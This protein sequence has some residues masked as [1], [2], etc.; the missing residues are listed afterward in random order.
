MFG[1]GESEAIGT[2]ID[3]LVPDLFRTAYGE[4]FDWASETRSSGPAGKTCETMA[5]RR[6]ASE[7][8]VE[9]SISSWPAGEHLQFIAITRDISDRRSL[10]ERLAQAQK[11]EAV[12][13]LTGGVAHDFNNLL[14]VIVGNLGLVREHIGDARLHKLVD[15]AYLAGKQGAELISGLLAFSRTQRLRPEDLD[16]N[17]VVASTAQLLE[18]TLGETVR[19]AVRP[20]EDLWRVLCDPVQLQNGLVN[21]SINARDAMPDGGCLTIE[22]ANVVL[23]ETYTASRPDLAPG[24]YAQ[25]TVSDTGTG[26][27][28]E[29]VKRVFDPFFTTKEVGKGSGLG[30]SMVYGFVK[31]SRGHIEIY[32]EENVGTAVKLYLPRATDPDPPTIETSADAEAAVPAGPDTILVVED[33]PSVRETSITMIEMLGYDCLQAEDGPSALRVLEG[34][35]HVSLMFSDVIMPGGMT[36]VELARQAHSRWP[37]LKILL[38]SGYTRNALP[39]T[40][41]GSQGFAL[42][43]KPFDG[44][45]LAQTIAGLLGK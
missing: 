16:L 38:T 33:N 25:L 21:L 12:G 42:L 34:S 32:S 40:V 17:S 10:E 4:D 1:Y 43:P 20:C 14:T 29:V 41:D 6:D 36:G 44:A 23:D 18:R 26:I 39:E 27:P 28:A 22:T 19:V 9:V 37:D 30:L 8:P 35:P 15:R 45:K 5:R 31:Q 24:P 13:Q 11:M 7:L 3:D 2:D